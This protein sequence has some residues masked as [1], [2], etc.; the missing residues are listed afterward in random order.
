MEE[1][2]PQYLA[3]ISFR[4]HLA[5]HRLCVQPLSDPPATP[6]FS[7]NRSH[8][9]ASAV[10]S[11]AMVPSSGVP[12]VPARDL[13]PYKSVLVLMY[14][15]V[16]PKTA[17]SMLHKKFKELISKT[18]G[19]QEV[20]IIAEGISDEELRQLNLDLDREE[21]VT[22][23]AILSVHSASPSWATKEFQY[24]D[25]VHRLC[26]WTSRSNLIAISCDGPAE[27]KIQRWLDS[28]PAPIF[29]RVSPGV[30]NATLLSGEARGLWLRATHGH[31]R[32]KAD[33]KTLSGQN[34][35]EALNPLEDSTFTMGSARAEFVPDI[36]YRALT[37]IVGVTP[38]RAKV[39]FQA[40]QSLLDYIGCI[41]DLLR[42]LEECIA[43]G[44]SDDAP[45]PW[46]AAEV[47][48][49]SLVSDAFEITWCSVDDLPASEVTP[50]LE[51]AARTLDRST[52]VVRGAPK[53]PDFEVDIGLDGKT[54]GTL[55]C[56]VSESGSTVH[57]NFGFRGTP[58]DPAMSREVLDALRH[59]KLLSVHYES[60]HAIT[61]GGV[62]TA[63]AQDA[64]FPGWQWF[65]Y[66][67]YDVCREKPALKSPQDIHDAIGAPGEDSL[68]S[69]VFSQF[70]GRGFLTC[71]DGANEVADFVLLGDDDELTLI[72]VKAAGS[73]NPGR[74]ISASKLEVVCSQATKNLRYL[75]QETLGASLQV[76][77]VPRPAVW[78]YGKRESDRSN[79]LDHL[80]HR[81]ARAPAKVLIIQPHTTRDRRASA[82]TT[83]DTTDGRRL[84]LAE[85]L[86]NGARG[87]AVA[88]GSD[89]SVGGAL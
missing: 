3:E 64:P 74:G 12:N 15:T 14:E 36:N 8:G 63:K 62:W 54:G 84:R 44:L 82:A 56:K 59:T 66:S 6:H 65:D 47:R 31:R 41:R 87:A 50:E 10:G 42:A 20:A 28:V 17:T 60:G 75:D 81:S 18:R 78:L 29:R 22:L 89:L 16:D 5:R 45:F 11:S 79:M 76:S 37:G 68:F 72:H 83:P 49:L 13:R 73:P 1:R 39:W 33:S 55:G 7:P 52:L 26:L 35:R 38:R 61:H 88:S 25:S 80:K 24:R 32:T 57:L 43:V 85:T 53:S 51:A 40:S 71:D 46:L 77:P 86:L 69:W 58:S 34:L 23:D 48:D 27:E 67:G 9:P 19:D 30:L 70:S 21:S 4:H 2:R